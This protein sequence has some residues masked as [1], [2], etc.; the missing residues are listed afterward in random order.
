MKIK[1]DHAAG[2]L[3]QREYCQMVLSK[4]QPTRKEVTDPNEKKIPYKV[5]KEEHRKVFE[6]V[7]Q[8][9]IRQYLEHLGFFVFKASAHNLVGSGDKAA[10]APTKNGIPDLIALHAGQF[11]AIEVKRAHKNVKISTTQLRVMQEIRDKGG[12]AF[13]CHSLAFV[14]EYMA[15][16]TFNKEV[17]TSW[18]LTQGEVYAC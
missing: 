5:P 7:I 15:L 2:A 11:W 6:G 4:K 10:F 3:P 1:K 14:K 17:R 18:P 12:H 13:A 9:E 8:R 16:V